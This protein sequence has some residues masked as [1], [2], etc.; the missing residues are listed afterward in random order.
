MQVHLL[1]DRFG[2]SNIRESKVCG[3]SHSTLSVR[4]NI[5]D[6]FSIIGIRE[7]ESSEFHRSSR[8]RRIVSRNI[9]DRGDII[10]QLNCGNLRQQTERYLSIL[11]QTFWYILTEELAL[12]KF[13]SLIQLLNRVQCPAIVEWFNVSNNK[14]K[15][16]LDSICGECHRNFIN[17]IG[18]GGMKPF[19]NGFYQ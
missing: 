4:Q 5:C 8:E 15:Y 7:H 6:N 16:G 1:F 13:K 10:G 12:V 17:H 18:I 11:V 14:Q 9:R 3:S 2:S 19:Q